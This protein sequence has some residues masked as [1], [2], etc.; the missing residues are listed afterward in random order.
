MLVMFYT[1]NANAGMSSSTSYAKLSPD[2][3]YVLAMISRSKYYGPKK[4]IITLNDGNS[5]DIQDKFPKSGLYDSATLRP[6]WQF[7]WFASDEL[8][9]CSNDFMDIA[10]INRSA[11][12]SDWAI[13]FFHRGSIVR[14][15]DINAILTGL[16]SQRFF[17]FSSWDWFFVWYERFDIEDNQLVLTTARRRLEFPGFE[18]DLRLQEF[19]RFDLQ[20]G[21]IISRTSVGGWYV[22]VSGTIISAIIS[23]TIFTIFRWILKRK[24]GKSEQG[25]D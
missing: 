8:M 20:T 7:D 12:S 13:R 6:I 1:P 24:K 4:L 15:F 9:R 11:M 25:A 14:S 16:K 10:I 23:A 2:G 3:R 18:I 5:I 19:C 17:R 21:S 22:W